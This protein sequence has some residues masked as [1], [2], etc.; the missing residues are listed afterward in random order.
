MENLIKKLKDKYETIV[1]LSTKSD[2]EVLMP[3]IPQKPYG[4][5]KISINF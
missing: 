4:E 1:Y 2:D 5:N 3:V